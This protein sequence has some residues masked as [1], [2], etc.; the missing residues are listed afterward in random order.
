MGDTVTLWLLRWIRV[1]R[2]GFKPWP[3]H[4]VVILGKTINSHNA[5]PPRSKNGY[6]RIAMEGVGGNLATIWFWVRGSHQCPTLDEIL[7]GGILCDQLVSLAGVSSN[8]PSRLMDMETRISSVWVDHLAGVQTLPWEF[9]I[10]RKFFDR[11]IKLHESLGRI[12][13]C[14]SFTFVLLWSIKWVT[15]WDTKGLLQIKDD[16][17]NCLH[18]QKI[19]LINCKDKTVTNLTSGESAF[20]IMLTKPKREARGP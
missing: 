11:Q 9:I 3:G 13:L 15:E 19:V 12:H 20:L 1:E 10:T 17:Y 5:H 2:S 14:W 7:G 16:Y 4:C 6:R 8:T 18:F